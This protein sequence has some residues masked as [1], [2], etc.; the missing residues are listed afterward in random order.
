[1]IKNKVLINLR[2]AKSDL[3]MHKIMNK[4][5]EKILKILKISKN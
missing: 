3:M 2:E 4:I 5:V 1:M